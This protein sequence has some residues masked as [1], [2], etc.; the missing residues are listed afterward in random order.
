MDSTSL[1][2]LYYVKESKQFFKSGHLRFNEFVSVENQLSVS[3]I[4]EIKNLVQDS[5]RMNLDG[6]SVYQFQLQP[7][8]SE[9][10]MQIDN[11]QPLSQ[12]SIDSAVTPEIRRN[13]YRRNQ[14]RKDIVQPTYA[15]I[16][17]VPLTVASDLLSNK[18]YFDKTYGNSD[19]WLV[20]DNNSFS[21]SAVNNSDYEDAINGPHAKEWEKEMRIEIDNLIS[22]GTFKVR[23]NLPPN[24]K[25]IKYKWANRIKRDE[26]LITRFRARLTAKDCGQKFFV[27]MLF[28]FSIGC[29]PRR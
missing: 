14:Y 10:R 16:S 29:Q 8:Q 18:F 15:S 7:I 3:E 9:N 2:Y 17:V 28:I 21:L 25:A 4:D 12:Q 5:V 22:K 27:A 19:I 13:P 20:F 26:G 11:E 6:Q 24:R 23:D 1:A